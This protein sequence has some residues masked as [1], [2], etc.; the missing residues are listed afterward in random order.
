MVHSAQYRMSK[1]TLRP[2]ED[3][4]RS[5]EKNPMVTAVKGPWGKWEVLGMNK[6]HQITPPATLLQNSLVACI[7]YPE[8]S[9]DSQAPPPPTPAPP[10]Q[11]V[12]YF[13]HADQ[14]ATAAAIP[15]LWT[16]FHLEWFSSSIFS[17]QIPK[18]FSSVPQPHLVSHEKAASLCPF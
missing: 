1:K 13:S 3:P 12:C 8:S 6:S 2:L 10:P 14:Q 18:Q 4:L 9:C 11:A 5:P 16:P 17:Q 15:A 7:S